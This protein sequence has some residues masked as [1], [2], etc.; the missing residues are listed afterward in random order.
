M[1]NIHFDKPE[2]E[3]DIYTG[4]I[5]AYQIE[6]LHNAKEHLDT[7]WKK[8]K[9]QF[10]KEY[11]QLLLDVAEKKLITRQTA[12]YIIAGF[13]FEKELVERREIND[14]LF[15]AGRLELPYA[16]A[17][18]EGTKEVYEKEWNEFVQKINSL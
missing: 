10:F 7:L 4:D 1:R 16:H 2:N 17:T 8:D 18:D 3:D 12:A 15:H 13:M 6:I 11:S 9:Q 14:I 5:D